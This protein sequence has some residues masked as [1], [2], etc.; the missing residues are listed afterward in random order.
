LYFKKRCFLEKWFSFNFFDSVD[1][2]IIT[3]EVIEKGEPCIIINVTVRNDYSAQYQPIPQNP[4]PAIPAF[5]W[6]CLTA[7]I[8]SG[9]DEINS[10][11]LTQLVFHLIDG[12]MRV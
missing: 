7:K 11:D 12:R 4:N 2:C 1:I 9:S 6:V 5:A 10:T 3:N 8:F